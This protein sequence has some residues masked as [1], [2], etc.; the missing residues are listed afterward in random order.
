MTDKSMFSHP[1]VKSILGIAV[2]AFFALY[3]TA[4]IFSL[5]GVRFSRIGGVVTVNGLGAVVV[6]VLDWG[7]AMLLH[8][9]FFQIHRSKYPRLLVRFLIIAPTLIIMAFA[10]YGLLGGFILAVR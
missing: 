7:F 5:S 10:I 4:C 9:L 6:G 8:A 2:P 3:G 1:L